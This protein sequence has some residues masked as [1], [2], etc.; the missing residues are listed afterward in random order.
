MFNSTSNINEKTSHPC[1]FHKKK[2][3]I[4]FIRIGN[5]RMKLLLSCK[6][7]KRAKDEP[8][9]TYK[10]IHEMLNAKDEGESIVRT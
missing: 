10:F 2:Q 3:K 4:N 7:S 1:Y 9:L 8:F 5:L 6:C